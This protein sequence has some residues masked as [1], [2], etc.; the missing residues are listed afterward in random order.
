[1]RRIASWVR[2]VNAM[3]SPALARAANDPDRAFE[4]LLRRAERAAGADASGDEAFTEDFRGLLRRFADVGT[5]SYLGWTA[6]TAELQMRLENR[7][8]IRRRIAEAPAIAD[9]PIDRPIV[10]VGLPRTATTLAHKVIAAP[11]GN[12]AP[13]MW[14]FRA[15]DRA[16]V[17]P[18][19]RRKRLK[20][21]QRVS[22]AVKYVAPVWQ[23]IHPN[24]AE[25]PEECVLALPHGL[26]WLTRFRLPGYREWLA[27]RDFTPDYAY[28]KE[29]L[30]V[31]QHGDRPRRWVL[32]SPF[33]MYNL[34]ALMRVFPDATIMWTH[35]DP[36]TVMGSWC[37][38]VETGMAMCNRSYDPRQIGSDWLQ[39]LSWMVDQGR[40][41]RLQVPPE[42]MVDVSYHQ[43]TA[44]PYGQ[45]PKIFERLGLEWTPREEGNLESVLARPGMRRNHEYSLARYGL[46]PD[47]VEEAF[48][49]YGR[50]VTTM[51]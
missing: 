24:S 5:I 34:G 4:R 17:D 20:Q 48:G 42:R 11:E 2:P 15:T 40:D 10:V 8:R 6:T 23:T 14:E 3:M 22:S 33:H 28:L 45:L 30:Q 27:E 51:R 13:L 7:L 38:L 47:M 1:M 25:T 18:G 31:L 44:D 37:S 46:D 39:T 19:L 49:D 36:Q 21:A 9:E 16:D 32:K 26:H 41:Q 50:M 29:F 12:R 35:R 43:L